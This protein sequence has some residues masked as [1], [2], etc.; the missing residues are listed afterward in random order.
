M[1]V[2]IVLVPGKFYV[3]DGFT[4]PVSGPFETREEAEADRVQLNIAD[5]CRALRYSPKSAL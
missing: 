4:G 2:Q 5:D 3:V 1:N